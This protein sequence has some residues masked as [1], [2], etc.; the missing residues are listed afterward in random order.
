[1]WAITSWSRVAVAFVGK[2]MAAVLTFAALLW[3][4]QPYVFCTFLFFVKLFGDWS[5][6]TAWGVVTDIG[7]RATACRVAFQNSVAGV[8]FI[9]APLVY[10]Y[11]ADHFGW[12]M[13]FA[14]V[15]VTYTCAACRG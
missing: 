4:E 7:G 1:M 5:L 8:G 9:A 11:I 6:A 12:R 2:G 14:A 3:Y 15:G 13:V 10:G